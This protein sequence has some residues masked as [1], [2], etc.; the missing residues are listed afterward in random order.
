MLIA[1]GVSLWPNTK[2]FTCKKH[3]GNSVIDY[4]LVSKGILDRTHKFS[5]VEWALEFERRTLC[6]DLKCMHRLDCEKAIEDNKQPH[7]RMNLKVFQD[8]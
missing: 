5:L 8:G 7:L 4:M 3:N 2:G 6:I 1:N